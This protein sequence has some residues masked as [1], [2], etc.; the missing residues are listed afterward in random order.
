MELHSFAT[1]EEAVTGA[2]YERKVYTLPKNLDE[3]VARL[4][5]DNL[6][7][8]QLTG[9]PASGTPL[10][11]QSETVRGV[12]PNDLTHAA[13]APG[14]PQFRQRAPKAHERR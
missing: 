7:G 9:V 5:L 12:L 1:N 4:H 13:L 8:A 14:G 2:A 10:W 3:M 6:I 11:N